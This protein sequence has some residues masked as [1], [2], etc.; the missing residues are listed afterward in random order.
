MESNIF[1][2]SRLPSVGQLRGFLRSSYKTR[3]RVEFIKGNKWWITDM[4]N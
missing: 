3:F 2:G 4:M 1:S